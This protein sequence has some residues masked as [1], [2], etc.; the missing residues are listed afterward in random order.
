MSV[1]EKNFID[2]FCNAFESFSYQN[3]YYGRLAAHVLLG[4]I[5]KHIKIPFGPLYI[6]PRVSLFLMQPSAT[7]KS[8]A[9]DIIKAV[10][11]RA[12]LKVDDIDR[13]RISWL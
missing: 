2:A 10:G 3:K 5:L 7:G 13:C 8:V 1:K 9:W 11:E 6:D 12:S 4:Q